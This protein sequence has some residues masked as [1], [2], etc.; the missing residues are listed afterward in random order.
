MSS[1][2]LVSAVESATEETPLHPQTTQRSITDSLLDIVRR[3]RD[4]IASLIACVGA[5]SMGF[6]LGYSSPAIQDP[7]I[8]KLLHSHM[9]RS[10]FG[11]LLTIGA[12]IG[13]PLGAMF[14]GRLGRKTTLIVCNVPLVVGWFLIIYATNV[15]LLY[16][17]RY[18]VT[19]V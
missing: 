19:T 8:A 15:V 9:R 5:M 17:G 18:V 7:Y 12:M 13:G 16:T 1:R 6:S 14:V 4:T 2:E 10:W 3:A 11:S